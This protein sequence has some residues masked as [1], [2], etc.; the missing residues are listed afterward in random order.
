MN[1]LTSPAVCFKCGVQ[2]IGPIIVCRGCGAAPRNED[3]LVRSLAMCEGIASNTQLGYCAK[4]IQEGHSPILPDSLLAK[5]R[6]ARKS[7]GAWRTTGPNTVAPQ[8]TTT[9]AAP[10]RPS[11]P[12]SKKSPTA[13]PDAPAQA[14]SASPKTTLTAIARANALARNPFAVIG[15]TLRDNRQKIVSL[16]EEKSLDVGDEAS[17]KARAELTNPRTRLSAEMAWIPGVSPRR[18]AQLIEQLQSKPTAIWRETGIPSLAHANMMAAAFALIEPSVDGRVEDLP[19]KHRIVN[20]ATLVDQLDVDEIM[21][22]LN[23]DRAISG[24]PEVSQRDSVESLLTERKTYYRNSIKDGLLERLT[25]Q[26][27]ISLVT[28]T[29][30]LATSGGTEHGPQLVHELIDAYEIQTQDVLE[31]EA[32]NVEQL[33][34]VARERAASGASAVDPI[35][36][37]LK[38]VATNWDM[39]AQPIQLSFKSRGKEHGPSERLVRDMRNLGVELFE[40]D[41]ID[42]AT[43]ITELLQKLFAE[44]PDMAAQLQEDRETL[45]Q[46]KAKNSV[47]EEI[48]RLREQATASKTVKLDNLLAA[49]RLWNHHASPI[50]KRELDRGKKHGDSEYLARELRSFSVDLFNDHDLLDES[51]QLS[52]FLYKTFAG[53][54]PEMGNTFKKD[55]DDLADIAKKRTDSKT[56]EDQWEKEVA[57]EAQWGLLVKKKLS[58]SASGLTW[59]SQH[60]PL[61]AITRIQWGATKHYTNSVYTGTTYSVTVGDDRSIAVID[62]KD[63]KTYSTFVDKLWRAAGV[64]IFYRLL[65]YLKAGKEF[66]F[67]TATLKDGGIVLARSHLFKAADRIPHDWNQVQVY[68]QNGAFVVESKADKKARVE[69][70]YS[71]SPNTHVLE[72]AI[73]SAFK[74]GADKLSD[75]LR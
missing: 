11:A 19:I 70:S 35:L 57:F 46:I 3:D 7:L 2:K 74:Q 61:N 12:V 41:M 17:Q 71:Q 45:A 26:S 63:E 40:H 37:Q 21:R 68:T 33:V 54:L 23:E 13:R 66:N 18:A 22:D 30:E 9:A 10:A 50:R 55:C 67:G 72:H 51:T 29:V 20:F 75:L 1:L 28:D 31:A 38:S 52:A 49:I 59:N 25:P 27:L 5:A 56:R 16:A 39:L 58:L 42:Q 34:N 15:A 32:K 8:Q 47:E 73:R 64:Q 48:S 60:F 69:L 53:D 44:L 4:T 62:P 14:P 43:Q 6:E 65:E 36:K 24:F